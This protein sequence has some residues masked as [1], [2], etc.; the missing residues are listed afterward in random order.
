MSNKRSKRQENQIAKDLE[1]GFAQPASGAI[2]C[3]PNDVC[4]DN[5]LVEAKYTEAKSFS[6]KKDYI[7]N[8]VETALKKG[9]VPTLVIQFDPEGA[10]YAVIRYEDLQAFDQYL[11]GNCRA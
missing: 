6:I 11:S 8:F 2:W 5:F 9:L 3:F 4:S 10:K 1:G 7:K